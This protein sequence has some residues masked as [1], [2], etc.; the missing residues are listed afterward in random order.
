MANGTIVFAL[1]F[2]GSSAPLLDSAVTLDG[3]A[4]C[5]HQLGIW[6]VLE[7]VGA[8]AG[9]LAALALALVVVVFP[10]A[11]ATLGYV[12]TL[13]AGDDWLLRLGAALAPCICTDVHALALVVF[14]FTAQGDHLRT[15]IPTGSLAGVTSNWFSGIYVGLGMGVAGFSLKWKVLGEAVPGVSA[16]PG[17]GALG[18][19]GTRQL[20]YQL[21]AQQDADGDEFW[22]A[23]DRGFAAPDAGEDDE[24]DESEPLIPRA[25]GRPA[26][27]TPS[28]TREP[29]A[30]ASLSQPLQGRE[31]DDGPVWEDWECPDKSSCTP[32][33]DWASAACPLGSG[34]G[35][36]ED[37]RQRDSCSPPRP[38][39]PL[40]PSTL[41]RGSAA[42]SCQSRGYGARDPESRERDDE[43]FE[44]PLDDAGGEED[45]LVGPAGALHHISAASR[46]AGDRHR[47]HR[48]GKARG[49]LRKELERMARSADDSVQRVNACGWSTLWVV[50]CLFARSPGSLPIS[51]EGVNAALGRS[52]ATLNGLLRV[53]AP[54]TVGD[55][56]ANDHPPAPCDYAG[57]LFV[58]TPR[59]GE[60]WTYAIRWVTGLNTVW[61]EEVSVAYIPAALRPVQV[62]VRGFLERIN[63]SLAI[64]KC[65]VAPKLPCHNIWDSAEACCKPHRNFHL[66]LQAVCYEGTTR[67]QPGPAQ[68]GDLEA[69]W[70]TLDELGSHV[71]VVKAVSAVAEMKEKVRDKV[72]LTVNGL[73]VRERVFFNLTLSELITRLWQYNSGGVADR[74]CSDFRYD[75]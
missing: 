14:L 40:A 6:Q 53:S 24:P 63:V 48:R 16:R 65:E 4:F 1:V 51:D 7:R 61:V 25:S 31:D 18:G 49:V 57:P 54:A 21:V 39:V 37:E 46:G 13:R 62:Q 22:T 43:T 2:F 28:R 36:G 10:L 42:E 47:G 34:R 35:R 69:A 32:S 33:D 66:V 19:G 70:Y 27:P 60:G 64:E 23:G 74:H 72:R 56:F 75:L 52:L 8:H 3:V 58:Q 9:G 73:F 38:P 67:G 20:D 44:D 12:G 15:E 30:A 68:L 29:L 71:P 50:L 45:P 41:P 5:R 26:G 17:S 11:V 55:C 59:E